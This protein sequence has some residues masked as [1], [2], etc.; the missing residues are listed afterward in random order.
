MRRA[1]LVLGLLALLG[2]LLPARADASFH[3]MKIREVRTGGASGS[4]VELQMWTSGQNLV[5][6]HEI[7]VYGSTGS[8]AHSYTMNSSVGSGTNQKTVLIAGAG[9]SGPA[10]D[11]T[12]AALNLPATGGAVCFNDAEP[13][14]CV[15]WG[16]FTGNASLPSPG[17]GSPA[18][19]S[20]VT[21]GQAL[22]RSIAPGCSTLLEPGDD[23]NNSAT[24]FSEQTPNPRPNSAAV[25]ESECT[26]PN[27]VIN[28]ASVPQGGKTQSQEINF[29]FS[30]NPPAGAEFECKREP[31]AATFASCTSP[32]SYSSLD[33]DNAV[34]GTTHTFQ[35]RAKNANGTDQSPATHTW[36]VDLVAPTASIVN[37][38]ADPSPG[39]AASFTYNS[40]EGSS[41]FECSL[42]EAGDPDDFSSCPAAGKS[43]PDPQHPAPFADGEWTFRVRAKDQ[44]GNQGGAASYTWTVDN[45]LQDTDPP[46]TSI[47][48]KPADPSSSSSASFTYS[49]DEAGSTFECKLDGAAFASCPTTGNTYQGLG[50]GSHT[51]QVRAKDE[52]GNT[53]P[54]P[55]GYTWSVSVP[56]PIDPPPVIPPQSPPPPPS[57]PETTITAKPRARTRDRTPTLR[58]RSNVGGAGYQCKVDRGDFKSCRSPFTTKKLTFGR[59]QVQ[60]RAVANGVTDPTPARSSFKVAKPKKKKAKRKRSR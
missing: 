48:N 7:T 6:G 24:D 27:T 41:T 33:G 19:P 47:L 28:T 36:T 53:D 18:S 46:E 30:A 4:Y 25:V 14:D 54:T 26:F 35:V 42:E 52:S 13:P 57:A 37:K 32:Q 40:N 17:A 12:D 2:A 45:S 29:T 60:V 1:G 8:V 38:P 9:Y 31:P 43:Y 55:A 59:H 23:T 22:H 39:N 21:A 11:F 49:S 51:F 10:A 58:F 56:D 5:S 15:S 34:T 3:L 50:N 44:V 16:N 20:G